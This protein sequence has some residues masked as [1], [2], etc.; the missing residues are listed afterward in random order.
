VKAKTKPSK[1]KV[2]AKVKPKV[3][4]KPSKATKPATPSPPT[5]SREDVRLALEVAIELGGPWPGTSLRDQVVE[6]L[7]RDVLAKTWV[8]TVQDAMT[9]GELEFSGDSYLVAP[10]KIAKSPLGI[11]ICRLL[12]DAHDSLTDHE[13][14]ADL[15]RA[16]LR[17]SLARIHETIAALSP[18]Y[19]EG[20]DRDGYWT[21]GDP[22]PAVIARRELRE[23]AHAQMAGGRQLPPQIPA[24]DLPWLSEAIARAERRIVRQAVRLSEVDMVDRR[25]QRDLDT[26]SRDRSLSDARILAQRV[27]RT[28]KAIVKGFEIRTL[29]V[30]TVPDFAAN[31]LS[32]YDVTDADRPRVI[33][34]RPL[35]A[36]FRQATLPGVEKDGGK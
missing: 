33:R 8:Q 4:E 19:V 31:L 3:T 15:G 22:P 27:K 9:R 36:R 35:P 1:G 5:A 17:P 13:L 21:A 10:A 16:G 12:G 29:S 32:T 7:G 18:T 6:S 20:N 30:C 14:S 26:K 34:S 24:A 28:T 25:A 23:K 11:A 2:S